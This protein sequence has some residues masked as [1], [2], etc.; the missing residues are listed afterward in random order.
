[1]LEAVIFLLL[2]LAAITASAQPV[3][4]GVPLLRQ[5]AEAARSA[6]GWRAEGMIG[7]SPLSISTRGPREMRFVDG[8]YPG[9]TFDLTVCDGSELWNAW[10]S[11]ISASGGRA[12]TA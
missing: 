9:D 1:M 3:G 7:E 11:G 5:V 8:R 10:D 2:I 6:K 4:D 12:A